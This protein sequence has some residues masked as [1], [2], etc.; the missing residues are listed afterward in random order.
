LKSASLLVAWAAAGWQKQSR[1]GGFFF[2]VNMLPGSQFRR[3]Y[4]EQR[5]SAAAQQRSSA[6]AQQRSTT[7][8]RLDLRL[9]DWAF[10]GPKVPRF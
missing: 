5:S 6:A 2:F 4:G 7:N 8:F 10:S 3:R 1:V 9:P